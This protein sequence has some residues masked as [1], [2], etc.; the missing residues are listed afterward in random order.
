[1]IVDLMHFSQGWVQFGYRFR[2]DYAPL[3]LLV[4]LALGAGGR[5][6]RIGYGL[7]ALSI[8]MV[9]WGVTWATCS[10]G[11]RPAEQPPQPV[12]SRRVRVGRRRP[13]RG[14]PDR[15]PGGGILGR[16][17]SGRR[18]PRDG[19]SDGFPS[20]VILGWLSSVVP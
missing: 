10:D 6:R 9:A 16:P 5:L 11:D 3:L 19:A 7:I 18:S 8:A 13:G 4:A 20:W 15:A 17:S 14:G 2:N 12:R 1:M